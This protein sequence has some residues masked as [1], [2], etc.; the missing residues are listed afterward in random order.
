MRRATESNEIVDASKNK[1]TGSVVGYMPSIICNKHGQQLGYVNIQ[2]VVYSP[3]NGFNLFSITKILKADE[4]WVAKLMK[5]L[6]PRMRRRFC[7][8]SI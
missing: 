6:F 2:D 8:I 3:K 5:F 4:N 1:I 7:L